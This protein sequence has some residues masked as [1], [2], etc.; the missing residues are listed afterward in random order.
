MIFYPC[1]ILR[2]YIRGCRTGS[3]CTEALAPRRH[4]SFSVGDIRCRHGILS[5]VLPSPPSLQLGYE[6]R[7]HH[8]CVPFSWNHCQTVLAFCHCRW[9][10]SETCVQL[11]GFQWCQIP[12]KKAKSS[13]KAEKGGGEDVA[14]AGNSLCSTEDTKLEQD[15]LVSMAKRVAAW[16]VTAQARTSNN[17]VEMTIGPCQG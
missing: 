4:T 9:T 6:R 12:G 10:T 17:R 14:A 1:W 16:R 2:R 5:W 8:L 7:N 13:S 15:Q 3:A 11:G